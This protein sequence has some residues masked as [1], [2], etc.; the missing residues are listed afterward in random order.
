M[1]ETL[2]IRAGIAGPVPPVQPAG[3]PASGGAARGMGGSAFEDLLSRRLSGAGAPS[4]EA[5][6]P[7]DAAATQL[8]FSRHAEERMKTRDVR[9]S[10]VELGRL[11]QAVARAA[12][13]GSRDSLVLMDR[14]AF[15]VNVPT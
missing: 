1:H 8:V 2:K 11:E 3:K 7:A 6:A 12:H 4:C 10:P 5:P 14:L 15:V 13:K 9:L